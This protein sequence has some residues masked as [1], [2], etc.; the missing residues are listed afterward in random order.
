MNYGRIALAGLVGTVVFSS[1]SVARPAEF[2]LDSSG[3]IRWMNLTDDIRVRARP[4]Q[5]LQAA[6]AL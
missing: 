1:F 5:M 3:T 4:E 2:L 6:K